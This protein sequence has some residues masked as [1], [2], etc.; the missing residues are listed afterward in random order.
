MKHTLKITLFLVLLFFSAQI[1]GLQVVNKY[2]NKKETQEKGEVIFKELPYN[3]TRPDIEPSRSFIWIFV[4]IIVGTVLMFFLIKWKKPNIWRFWFLLSVVVTLCFSL[5]AFMN[6]IIATLLSIIL[7]LWKVFRP[8]IYIHNIT[9]IFIYGGLAAIFVPLLNITSAFALLILISA[10]DM[11]AVW[12]SKHM[13]KLA[14]FQTKTK[15]FAGILIPYKKL[16]PTKKG[17][18]I[19]T[20]RIRTAIL[21]GGDIGFPLIFAGVTM[22]GLIIKM[23]EFQSFF[24]ASIICV[25]ATISLLILLLK[26]KKDRF[27][28]AMPFISLGCFIGYA[29]V[30]MMLLIL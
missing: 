29:I 6:Y 10:Y 25:C 9:E 7:G 26:S 14:K 1:L 12:K 21:G 4:A 28:P 24:L 23:T 30:R 2:I 22:K 19:I 11:Y 13:I 3:I 5:A 27:Y 20:K 17:K 18:K 8:N 15:I 16:P